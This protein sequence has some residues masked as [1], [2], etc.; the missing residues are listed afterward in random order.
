MFEFAGLAV[1]NPSWVTHNARRA[2]AVTKVMRAHRAKHPWC[3][4]CGRRK[5]VQIHHKFP[6]SIFPELAADPLNLLTLC[7][8]RC[9]ITIGHNGNYKNYV[10]N[11]DDVCRLLRTIQTEAP[12]G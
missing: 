9:H 2:W 6:V 11:V 8:K 10:E 7:A 3:R 5:R 1:R 12:R 4:L